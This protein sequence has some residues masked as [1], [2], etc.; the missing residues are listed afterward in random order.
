MISGEIVSPPSINRRP[1][2]R[3]SHSAPFTDGEFDMAMLTELMRFVV[4]DNLGG[5]PV[6]SFRLIIVSRGVQSGCK[7][8]VAT[9]RSS[10][11]CA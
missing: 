4:P 3:R 6:I 8:S 9:G 10:S 1:P 2:A 5:L 11:F 7:R